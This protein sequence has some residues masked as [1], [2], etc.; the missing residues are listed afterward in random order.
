MQL[1]LQGAE[2]KG[3]DIASAVKTIRNKLVLFMMDQRSSL[4]RDQDSELD[5]PAPVAWV[6]AVLAPVS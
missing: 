3:A 5:L 4:R 6:N 2:S 1:R